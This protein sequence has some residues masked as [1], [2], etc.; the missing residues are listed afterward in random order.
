MGFLYAAYLLNEQGSFTLLFAQPG[1]FVML[2]NIIQNT[3]KTTGLIKRGF[4]VGYEMTNHLI[5]FKNNFFHAQLP[6]RD[7]QTHYVD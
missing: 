5:V 3:V 1:L 4:R 7:T 2:L 6:D